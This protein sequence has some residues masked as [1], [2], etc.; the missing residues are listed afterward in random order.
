MFGS[1]RHHVI[2]AKSSWI[3][4]SMDALSISPEALLEVDEIHQIYIMTS[5][6]SLLGPPNIV[7]SSNLPL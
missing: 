2:N 5:C 6:N 3:E 1:Q 4:K 7:V